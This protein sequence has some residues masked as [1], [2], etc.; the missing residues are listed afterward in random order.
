MFV[1]GEGNAMFHYVSSL[2]YSFIAAVQRAAECAMP[3][4]DR[5]LWS[6]TLGYADR[7]GWRRDRKW[8]NFD[9]LR[10]YS[11][12]PR[13]RDSHSFKEVYVYLVKLK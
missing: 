5:G 7:W 11:V 8:S 13:T 4:Q 3:L 2:R 12:V 6:G 1:Y 9:G 10:C